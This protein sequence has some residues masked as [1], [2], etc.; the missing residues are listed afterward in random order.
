MCARHT[1]ALDSPLHATRP[2]RAI[3]NPDVPP[4]VLHVPV[5][6]TSRCLPV[7]QQGHVKAPQEPT[8]TYQLC[9][10]NATL[11]SAAPR[12]SLPVVQFYIDCYRACQAGPS[13]SST[14]RPAGS[15]TSSGAGPSG[16]S[17]GATPAP[18]PSTNTS[19]SGSP[20]RSPPDSLKDAVQ[21]AQGTD[22]ASPGPG[23]DP[24][25]SSAPVSASQA[26]AAAISCPTRRPTSPST[27][28]GSGGAGSGPTT[29]S[30]AA[31]A[32]PVASAAGD[33]MAAPVPHLSNVP[34]VALRLSCLGHR[35]VVRRVTDSKHYWSKSMANLF[36]YSLLPGTGTGYVVD[37]VFREHFR[38]G[39]MSDRYR[40]VLLAG[41][42]DTCCVAFDPR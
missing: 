41:E 28:A 10:H 33:G 34:E 31:T 23:H 15:H 38:A 1:E 11:Y 9:T 37:P 4:S 25:T 20:S 39:R 3:P 32:S 27:S 14:T 13:S 40:C 30:T 6:L 36:C 26:A 7:T 21:P 17:G 24:D 16:G 18:N 19:A 5:T 42:Q 12:P 22:T 29:A 8:P 2:L 35:V